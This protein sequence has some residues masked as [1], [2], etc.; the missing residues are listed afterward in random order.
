[1]N[2]FRR[3][4]LSRLLALC[5]AVLVIGISVTALALAVGSGPTPP[6]KPLAQAVHDALS[7]PPVAGFS[8][9][10]KLT[11]NLL[12]GANLAS[13]A[14]Q[15][16]AGAGGL[17]SNPLLSGASGRLW[18]ASDGRVRLELQ[19]EKGDTQLL[20]DGTTAELYDASTNTLYR[21]TP[22][23]QDW[24]GHGPLKGSEHSDSAA[25]QAVPSVAEIEKAIAHINKHADLSGATPTDVGGKAAYT[26]RV[27][28]KQTGSLIGGA[29]LSFDAGNGLP[30]RAAIYS[31]DSSSPV[32]E[33]ATS[34]VAYGPVA[35]SVFAFTPPPGAKIV[36]V[37]PPEG[38]PSAKRSSTAG[39][40]TVTSHGKGL[41]SVWVLEQKSPAKSGESKGLEGL[42]KVKINGVSAS[43]L[44]TALGTVLTFERSGVS[45][46]LAGAVAPKDIEALARGL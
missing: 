40:P 43:E 35:D 34:N 42:P 28:P 22:S 36:V 21:Y 19:A 24:A 14:E 8:A 1:M 32:I 2:I 45:Y 41:S 4:P 46:V 30:L 9:D 11:N 16:T 23:S 13:G 6:A 26:V 27:S 7:G 12:E 39:K 5:G 33:L 10:V 31:A 18:V 29:E 20:Y 15:G 37:R 17:A 25:S 38:Q 3:L 44:K